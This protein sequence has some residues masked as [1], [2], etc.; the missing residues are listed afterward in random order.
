MKTDPNKGDIL[1]QGIAVTLILIICFAFAQFHWLAWIIFIGPWAGG[2]FFSTRQNKSW[3]Q[4]GIFLLLCGLFGL[5][6]LS[7]M[8]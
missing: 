6:L 2:T 7:A 4:L 8:R 1:W 5:A 3:E